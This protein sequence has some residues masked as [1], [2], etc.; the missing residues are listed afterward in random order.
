[1]QLRGA[2]V[3][4]SHSSHDRPAHG[5]TSSFAPGGALSVRSFIFVS[6]GSRNEDVQVGINAVE[7]VPL[8]AVLHGGSTGLIEAHSSDSYVSDAGQL[9]HGP[10][11]TPANLTRIHLGAIS[12]GI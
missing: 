7:L 12:C 6:T 3:Y 4:A 11:R 9:V 10:A 1:M 2:G 5:Q 8:G